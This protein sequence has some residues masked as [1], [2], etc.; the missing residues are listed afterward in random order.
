MW[1]NDQTNKNALIKVISAFI[2]L[3]VHGGESERKSEVELLLG[4]EQFF[5]LRSFGFVPLSLSHRVWF[6]VKFYKNQNHP[7]TI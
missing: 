3:N 4:T 2:L 1:F 5:L 6:G 7:I